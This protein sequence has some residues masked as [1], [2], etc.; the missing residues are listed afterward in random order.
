MFLLI[1]APICF[2]I[3]S[4][5][6]SGGIVKQVGIKYSICNVG[7]WRMYNTNQEFVYSDALNLVGENTIEGRVA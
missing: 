5:P 6:S 1:I 7:A 4:Y 3:S 2:G